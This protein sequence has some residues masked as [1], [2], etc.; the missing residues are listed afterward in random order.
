MPN[1]KTIREAVTEAV[2]FE[3]DHYDLY[4]DAKDA[5]TCKLAIAVIRN[6]IIGRR[7]EQLDDAYRMELCF[8]YGRTFQVQQGGE[9]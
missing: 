2:A 3:S 5:T 4:L 1:A 8:K 9:E 6:R 7:G